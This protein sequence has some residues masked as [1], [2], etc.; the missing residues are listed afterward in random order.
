[1]RDTAAGWRS[2]DLGDITISGFDIAEI[3]LK[4]DA[5]GA[6]RDYRFSAPELERAVAVTG[7]TAELVE[8][9]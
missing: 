3:D 6:E 5:A 1:M 4:I 9:A 2:R 8:R 7:R